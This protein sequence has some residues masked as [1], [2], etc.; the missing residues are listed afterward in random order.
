MGVGYPDLFPSHFAE[1]QDDCSGPFLYRSQPSRESGGITLND[2]MQKY[3]TGDYT[4]M[5]FVRMLNS[6]KHFSTTWKKL[7]PHIRT[8]ILDILSHSNSDLSVDLQVRPSNDL[9]QQQHT[10]S[11]AD[12]T[13]IN[14]EAEAISKLTALIDDLKSRNKN[15]KNLKVIP[16]N[17]V[18]N[19]VIIIIVAIVAIVIGYLIACVM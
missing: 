3:V 9:T 17:N 1:F 11:F 5:S 10:E 2:F 7:P 8:E 15:Y 12:E 16:C 13:P 14:S 19:L 18:S 6:L 4:E